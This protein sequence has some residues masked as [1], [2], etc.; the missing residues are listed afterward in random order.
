MSGT[1]ERTDSVAATMEGLLG[2]VPEAGAAIVQSC[3]GLFDRLSHALDLI[4]GLKL[5]EAQSVLMDALS[6]CHGA[7]MAQLAQIWPS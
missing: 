3:A 1:N 5:A 2:K 4:F 6:S 7:V